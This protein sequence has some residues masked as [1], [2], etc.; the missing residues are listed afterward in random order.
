MTDPFDS[1]IVNL[2][3][4]IN[5]KYFSLLGILKVGSTAA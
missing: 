1:L 4:Q 3:F 2:T 5:L